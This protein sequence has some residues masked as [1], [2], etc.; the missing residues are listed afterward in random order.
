MYQQGVDLPQF[1]MRSG[2]QRSGHLHRQLFGDLLLAVEAS[3]APTPH[4]AA[5]L[6]NNAAQGG[7]SQAPLEHLHGAL[8]N[9]LRAKISTISYASAT[10]SKKV[11]PQ[12]SG[13][14]MQNIVG[15]I[16]RLSADAPQVQFS[17]ESE[18]FIFP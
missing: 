14:D 7:N 4:R 10:Q 8:M 13:V 6:A 18:Y 3:Q 1:G 15:A 17:S 12:L 9:A 2:E 16:K 11:P 5:E